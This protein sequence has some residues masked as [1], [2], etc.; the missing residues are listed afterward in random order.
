MQT[1]H[2]FTGIT[3]YSDSQIQFEETPGDTADEFHKYTIDWQQEYIRWLIDDEEV[4]RVDKDDTEV[5]G[6]P[7]VY[8]F[9]REITPVATSTENVQS[10]SDYAVPYTSFALARRIS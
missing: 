9:Q 2:W 5:D 3:N 8:N 4:R 6:I 7:Y 10:L 1:N